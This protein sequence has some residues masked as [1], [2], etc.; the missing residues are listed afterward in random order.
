MWRKSRTI[1]KTVLHR[2]QPV[3]GHCTNALDKWKSILYDDQWMFHAHSKW[4]NHIV[5]GRWVKTFNQKHVRNEIKRKMVRT[6]GEIDFSFRKFFTSQTL[7]HA[8]LFAGR[9]LY[10]LHSFIQTTVNGW[11]RIP[12]K[13]PQITD[14]VMRAEFYEFASYFPQVVSNRDVMFSN[15]RY[16]EQE[17][18]RRWGGDVYITRNQWE[19]IDFWPLFIFHYRFTLNQSKLWIINW[20][21]LSRCLGEWDV[22]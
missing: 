1:A 8:N 7:R 15:R 4:V 10:F 9:V 18:R 16:C 17:K 3:N 2:P 12:C 11:W 20:M 19:G 13:A 21:L 22:E 5:I 6:R 14:H